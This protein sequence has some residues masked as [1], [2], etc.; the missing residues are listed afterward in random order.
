MIDVSAMICADCDEP[1]CA[2]LGCKN[3]TPCKRCGVLFDADNT[4]ISVMDDGP[5]FFS[6][7]YHPDCLSLPQ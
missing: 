1:G 3:Y 5:D 6:G 7:H 4:I 2:V